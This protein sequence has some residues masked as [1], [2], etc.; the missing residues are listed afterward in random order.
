MKINTALVLCAGYGK[1]LNPIT[2]KKP[3]PLIEI[4]NKSLLSIT[5][6]LILSLGVNRIFVNTF[7]MSDQI[8]K[9]VGESHYKNIVKIFHD[10]K[11]LLDTG[12]GVKNMIKNSDQENF[13][14]FN[15][16][17]I[18][19]QDYKEPIIQMINNYEQKNFN[20]LLLVVKRDYSLDKSLKGDFQLKNSKLT[21]ENNNQYIYTGMQIINKSLFNDNN[22]KIFSMN[23][24]WNKQIKKDN[25]NGFECN[26]K[27][28]HL[29]NIEIYKKLIKK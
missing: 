6:E 1:R 4:N 10:G 18:W 22:D 3:K 9:F 23:K 5:L 25:L 8:I 19:V 12:G 24:I 14:V 16:D 20:N 2:L 28:V 7:Y 29:T 15:P 13:L 26:L 11:N 21:K 27:F 17:T